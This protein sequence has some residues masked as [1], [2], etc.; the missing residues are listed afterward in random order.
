MYGPSMAIETQ[1]QNTAVKLNCSDSVTKN[2][3]S[4]NYKLQK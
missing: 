3:S 2:N 1:G 4:A